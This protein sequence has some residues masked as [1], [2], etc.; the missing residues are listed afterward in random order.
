LF[1]FIRSFQALEEAAERARRLYEQQLCEE[2]LDAKD[3]A[4]MKRFTR[5]HI[6]LTEDFWPE[7]AEALFRSTWRQATYP[8][9]YIKRVAWNFRQQRYWSENKPFIRIDAD[10]RLSTDAGRLELALQ[11]HSKPSDT[12]RVFELLHDLPLEGEELAL[13]HAHR[14]VNVPRS[15]L[16][17]VLGDGW[18]PRRTER[19]RKRMERK[20]K[21]YQLKME[22]DDGDP[23][24]WNN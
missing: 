18:D 6:G 19:V 24:E 4:S 22:A 16:P 17:T 7:V 3:V 9:A 2:V 21:I 14:I 20:L 12:H 13:F 1:F 5:E 11:F 15:A 8:L 23:E 10:E